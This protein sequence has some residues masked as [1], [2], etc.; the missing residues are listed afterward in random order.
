MTAEILTGSRTVLSY[1][2]EP[3]VRMKDEALNER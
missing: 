3:L 2:S 1:I